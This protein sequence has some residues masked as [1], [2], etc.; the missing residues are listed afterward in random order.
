MIN[1]PRFLPARALAQ[2]QRDPAEGIVG[3]SPGFGQEWLPHFYTVNGRRGVV[4]QPHL[5][6]DEALRDSR[7][8]AEKMR[9]DCF[10][11][12]AQV[13]RGSDQSR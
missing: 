9:A 1:D 10:A 3:A 7:E 12:L 13:G 6:Y 8:N 11:L 2:S 4:S 5:N